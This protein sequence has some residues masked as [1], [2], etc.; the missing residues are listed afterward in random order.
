MNLVDVIIPFTVVLFT[1]SVGVVLLYQNFQKNLMALELEKA[2]IEAKQRDKLLQNSIM[3]QEEERKRIAQDLHDELGAVIS[4]MKMNLTLI[5]QKQYDAGINDEVTSRNV[6]NLIDLSESAMASVR[7]ISHQLMP[8]QLETFGLVKSIESFIWQ[9]N[10]S[11]NIK[12]LFTHE[13]EW[14]VIKWPVAL[15]IYRI[16]I[17]LINNTIKHAQ[18]HNIFLEFN[19]LDENLIINFKDD[20]IGFP[21]TLE[22]G[23]GLGLISMD[24]RA[25]A[26]NGRFSYSN[27]PDSGIIAKLSVCGY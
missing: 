26:M 25:R 27:G 5:R 21:D 4:I 6:Q 19:Y 18:A 3:V 12:V 8:P 11:G 23:Q 22:A 16:I 14:P 13:A 10:Q 2:A 15:G 7:N 20:G 17:E 24:A 9:I 1:I